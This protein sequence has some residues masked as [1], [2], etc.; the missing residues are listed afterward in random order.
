[1]VQDCVCL[2]SVCQRGV[3]NI[4]FLMIFCYFEIVIL[5]MLPFTNV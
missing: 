2:L 4:A 3:A 5:F 1:M